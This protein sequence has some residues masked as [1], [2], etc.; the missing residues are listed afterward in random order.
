MK[1]FYVCGY[2]RNKSSGIIRKGA[3]RH[4]LAVAHSPDEAMKECEIQKERF[5]EK[6]DY[7]I[8]DGAWKEIERKGV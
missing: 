3:I 7:R 4:V 1:T 5:G 8:F 2:L 6:Y